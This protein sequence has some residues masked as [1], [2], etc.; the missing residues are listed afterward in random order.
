M[1]RRTVDSIS[2]Q[3]LMTA[4]SGILSGIGAVCVSSLLFSV[5]IT[6]IDVP[7]EL[8]RFMSS[9][10]LCAGCV[11]AGYSVSKR[12]R[13]NGLLTGIL[14]GIVIFFTVLITGLIFVRSFTATGFFSKLIIICV[15]S[16]AGGILG[17]NSRL[18]IR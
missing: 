17:V 15:C 14:C 12:R 13:K 16:A 2:K 9:V 1:R 18:K 11:A 4:L 3:R 5:I 8:M 6:Y 7:E 10:S